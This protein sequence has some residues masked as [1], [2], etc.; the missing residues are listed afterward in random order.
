MRLLAIVNPISGR[1][2]K[3]RVRESILG[4]IDTTKYEVAINSNYPGEEVD[5]AAIHAR[6]LHADLFIDDRAVGG[7]PDCGAIYEVIHHRWSWREYYEYLGTVPKEE[8]G[9]GARLLGR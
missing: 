5:A 1:T 4:N 9:F 3:A 8:K 6:K 7:L 2:S